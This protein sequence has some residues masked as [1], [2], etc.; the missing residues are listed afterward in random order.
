MVLLRNGTYHMSHS[1]STVFVKLFVF[2]SFF[3]VGS[4]KLYTFAN[5][6]HYRYEKSVEDARCQT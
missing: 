3:F 6:K 2:F 4:K 5:T 1:Y